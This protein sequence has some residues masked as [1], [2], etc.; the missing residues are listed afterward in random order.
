M[1]DARWRR[2]EVDA[3]IGLEQRQQ[4]VARLLDDVELTGE[5]RID[6][7]LRIGD[8][9][10]FDAVDLHDLA[11]GKTRGRLRARLVLVE[12]DVDRLVAGLPLVLLED[13]RTRAREVGDLR[14]GI[15]V[16][17]AL[18]HHEGHVGGRLAQ[19]EQHEARL[20]LQLDGEALGVDRRHAVDEAHQLLADAVLGAPALDGGDA[21]FRR[22]RLA[23]VPQKSVA[24]RERVGETVG[25]DLPLLRHL[26]LDFALLVLCE[27]R[28]VDHV[29]VV[30]DDVGGRPDRVEDLQVRVHVDAQ[31]LLRE[32]AGGTEPQCHEREE[33]HEQGR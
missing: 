17:D 16:G 3:G 23:V 1:P 30:A 18:R 33:R 7:L 15:G 31:R 10:P 24:Q 13:E 32:G 8:G 25:R 11:A 28:V 22:H 27:Q 21:V 5:Q 29:A 20:F 12:L 2:D 9:A 26:R 19:A 4:V 14:I 6:G